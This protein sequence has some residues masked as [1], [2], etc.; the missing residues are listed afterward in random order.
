M[1]QTPSRVGALAQL[2]N[3]L[4]HEVFHL[5]IPNGVALDGDYD[6]FYEGFT[7]YQAARAAVRL[8][9]LTWPEFLDA[10]A[11]AYDGSTAVA[12]APLLSLIDASKQRW[13][14][15]APSVY[16]KA[17]VVAFLY[18]LNLRRQTGGKRSLDVVYQRILRDHAGPADIKR[19]PADGNKVAIDALASELSSRD[20][21]E[22][23][24]AAPV[25]FDLKNEL[26]PFGLG[27]EK[28]VRTRISV[29]NDIDKRQRDLL[30]QL[31]YNE[32]RTRSQN[33]LR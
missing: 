15:G 5:W 30:K 27:V 24:I 4:T 23:Y 13:T 14:V 7:M 10:I 20:F 25:T 2:G 11:R 21:V 26:A 12:T 18:D 19:A 32:P 17:M 31:G 3:A 28:L 33:R 6:W 16:S 8:G 22:R 9:L 29:S 1:G